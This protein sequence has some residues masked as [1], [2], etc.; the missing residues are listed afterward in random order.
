[1]ETIEL[2]TL[3]DITD[4]GVRRINQGSSEQLDQYKNYTTLKQC[5]ELSSIIEH[6]GSPSIEEVDIKGLGF[7][8]VFKGTHKVWTWRFYPDRAGAFASDQGPLGALVANVDNVPVIKKL[9]ETI[10]IDKPVFE[11]TDKRLTNTILKIISG[12]D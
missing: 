8:S 12:T 11:L 9:T 1:M 6:D 2:K 7:G 3:I 10:N 4:T 5:I